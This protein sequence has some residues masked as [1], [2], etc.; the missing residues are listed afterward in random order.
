MMVDQDSVA[1][2]DAAKYVKFDSGQSFHQDQDLKNA[3]ARSTPNNMI[4]VDNGS[5]HGAFIL[6]KSP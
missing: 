6:C 3:V 4:L 1:S 5:L 2:F